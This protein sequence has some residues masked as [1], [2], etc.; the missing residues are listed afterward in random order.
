MAVNDRFVA[1]IMAMTAVHHIIGVTMI[2]AAVSARMRG[3]EEFVLVGVGRQGN[4]RVHA[5]H[6]GLLNAKHSHPS[7]EFHCEQSEKCGERHDGRIRRWHRLP[8]AQRPRLERGGSAQSP[9]SKR[10][11]GLVWQYFFTEI[12]HF[13][14]NWVGAIY[15]L[16]QNRDD[17]YGVLRRTSGIPG[18]LL[19]GLYIS[20]PSE[21]QLLHSPVF[22]SAEARG[23]AKGIERYMHSNEAGSGFRAP[24]TRGLHD[25]GGGGTL[26]DCVDP[27]L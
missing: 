2:V 7:G 22:R 11:A 5:V 24:L 25:P 9:E 23:I 27:R 8:R 19:E 26:H 21:A 16:D 15:R 14:A 4:T 13:T 20:D 6:V 3:D 1:A 17:Y 10:L 12:S 18:T